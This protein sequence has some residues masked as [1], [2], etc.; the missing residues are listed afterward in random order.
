MIAEEIV[1]SDSKEEAT[2]RGRLP[3]CSRIPGKVTSLTCTLFAKYLVFGNFYFKLAAP[4]S[5][6]TVNQG[7]VVAISILANENDKV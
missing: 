5:L 4:L 6:P 3:E 1:L 7:K 2:L